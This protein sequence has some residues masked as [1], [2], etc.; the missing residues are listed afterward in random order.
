[1]VTEEEV[2]A[3]AD[4]MKHICDTRPALYAEIARAALEAAEQVRNRPVYKRGLP[5]SGYAV[6]KHD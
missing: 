6:P 5:P 2:V 4:M 3:A 1:M